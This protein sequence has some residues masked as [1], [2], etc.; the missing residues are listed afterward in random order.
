[1]STNLASLIY[2]TATPY[3]EKL[4]AIPRQKMHYRVSAIISGNAFSQ[5]DDLVWMLTDAVTLPGHR[6]ATQTINQYNRKRVI[7]T[8]VDYDPIQLSIVDTVDNSFLKILIAYNNY[9]YGNDSR[10][11]GSLTKPLGEYNLDTTVDFPID[12]GYRPVNHSN[13]YFFEELIIHREYANEDQQVRIIHPMIQSVSHD[14]L[15]YASGADAV[16]WNLTF[17]YEGINYQGF[18]EANAFAA[19]STRT[20]PGGT[21][22]TAGATQAVTVIDGGEPSIVRD[23]NGNPVV[24]SNGNPVVSGRPLR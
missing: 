21:V 3:G 4:D 13:K 10:N 17:E 9:Y 22:Q 2:K 11:G 16:R 14:Q 12:F 18:E 1:M 7:Q 6:Y 19:G 5:A 8:K 20:D 24:D 15:S 23:R